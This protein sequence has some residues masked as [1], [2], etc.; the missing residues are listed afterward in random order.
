MRRSSK[1]VAENG[2]L[3]IDDTGP[4]VSNA[5]RVGSPRWYRWLADAGNQGFLF[6]GEAGHFSARREVRRGN[7]YWYAYRRRGGKLH[8][9]Y[10]GRSEEV[11]QERLDQASVR[12]AGRTTLA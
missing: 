8:K 2:L 7:P 11:T 10:L 4:D 12:L 5:V 3:L 1:P 6:K 9:A